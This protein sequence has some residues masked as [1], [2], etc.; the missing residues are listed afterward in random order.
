MEILL[1]HKATFM[2]AAEV[3]PLLHFA[4]RECQ[5][6]DKLRY[7][8]IYDSPDGLGTSGEADAIAIDVWIPGP[9]VAYPFTTCYLPHLMAG[10][11]VMSREEECLLTIA[12]ELRHVEQFHLHPE[13][14]R[15][16]TPGTMDDEMELD[17][18]SFGQWVCLKW[19][20][21]KKIRRA[22]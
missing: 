4:M 2:S 8:N 17:A 6:L 19:R 15:G 14:F 1:N 20:G 22:A 9:D 10:F 7:V 12:H 18:E 3:A 21:M 16:L 11:R 13:R 5:F